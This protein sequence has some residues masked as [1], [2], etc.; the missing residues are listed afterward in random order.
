MSAELIGFEMKTEVIRVGATFIGK[1][2]DLHNRKTLDSW[3]PMIA[4]LIASPVSCCCTLGAVI[5]TM[6]Q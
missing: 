1:K 3:G 5:R 4:F 2:H 6:F